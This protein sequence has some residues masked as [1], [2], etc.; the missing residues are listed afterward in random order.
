MKKI[1]FI[2][3]IT[4]SSLSFAQGNL[5]F[6]Q[7]KFIEYTTATTAYSTTTAG[8]ITVPDI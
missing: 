1:L 4:I 5:Q 6:N 8:V 3:A 2:L 7:V